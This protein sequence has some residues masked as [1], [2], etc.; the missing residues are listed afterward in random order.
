M[1]L[2]DAENALFLLMLLFLTGSAVLFILRLSEKKSG[3]EQQAQRY[4][5]LS[6][7]CI[8]IGV[9]CWL[10]GSMLMMLAFGEANI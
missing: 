10:A 9:F 2:N 3:S 1:G 6:V 4:G 7:V 8:C 5:R